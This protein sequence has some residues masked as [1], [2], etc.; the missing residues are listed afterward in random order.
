MAAAEA[1]RRLTADPLA[2]VGTLD[3]ATRAEVPV[4]VRAARTCS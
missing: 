2:D 3:A 4:R 1:V